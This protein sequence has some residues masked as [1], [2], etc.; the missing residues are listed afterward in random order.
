M[1]QAERIEDWIGADVIDPEGEKVGK[2]EDVF[3]EDGSDEDEGS[4]GAI[5]AGAFGRKHRL[6]PL[7][8]ATV[9]PDYVRV[10][11]DAELVKG[12][13]EASDDGRISSEESAGLL[14]HYG[15]SRSSEGSGEYEAASAKAEREAAADEAANRADELEAEAE[16]EGERA[17]T[18]QDESQ[19]AQSSAEEATDRQQRALTE[20]ERLRQE[21]EGRREP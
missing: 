7:A 14:S 8:G 3:S 11:Y 5:K 21:A 16:R 13:P 1:A 6:I 9:G 19:T 20:A 4:I 18:M 2:L 17:S 15:L 12:S 10:R